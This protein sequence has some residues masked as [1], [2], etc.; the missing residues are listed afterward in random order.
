M[1]GPL[2]YRASAFIIRKLVQKLVGGLRLMLTHS[3]V[4]FRSRDCTAGERVACVELGLQ[5]TTGASVEGIHH[6]ASVEQDD[7]RCLAAVRVRSLSRSFCSSR[8]ILE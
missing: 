6:D 2:G 5:K 8:R 7:H 3:C 1:S 4:N